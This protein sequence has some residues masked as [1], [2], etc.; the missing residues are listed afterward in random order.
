MSQAIHPFSTQ[1]DDDL[2]QPLDQADNNKM[3]AIFAVLVMCLTVGY[4]NMFE[5][6][7][8]SWQDALY[9]HGW[10]VPVFAVFLLYASSGIKIKMTSAEMA[11]TTA[12]LFICG[13][14]LLVGYF[15]EM[16]L[17]SWVSMPAVCA[18]IGLAVYHLRHAQLFEVSSLMR[19]A[20]VGILLAALSVRLV[21]ARGDMAPLDRLSF[22]VALIG[23][24]MIVGGP[25]LLRWAGLP[26]GFIV[27]MFP[28]PSILENTFLM[29]LQG[30]AAMVSTWTLQILGAP[31]MRDGNKLIVDQIPLEV[32]EA[33]S[34]LRMATIF[35]AMSVALAILM[36]ERPWWDRVAILLSAIPVALITNVIRITIT[37]LLLMC[38]PDNENLK[39]M[40]HDNAGFAM[41][42]I[43]MGILWLELEILRKIS[44]P[45]DEEDYAA[46]GTVSS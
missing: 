23:I 39:V 33:C 27:F 3:W 25:A 18:L 46:F 11:I 22:V 38:F 1:L 6:A 19:W 43:A 12:L 24:A 28:L 2:S 31:A 35:G 4:W 17:P 8:H 5:Y 16:T 44:V 29:R 7:S 34:G 40:I 26:L 42:P 9:S 45:I 15:K 30:I 20:G 41:M 14:V 13:G 37:A 36:T 32:A 21:A 10:I